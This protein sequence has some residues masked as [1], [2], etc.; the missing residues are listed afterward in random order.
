[1]IVSHLYKIVFI[2]IPKTAGSYTESILHSIDMSC[3]DID[4][5][6]TINYYGHIPFFKIKEMDIYEEIKDY[7]FF[8]VVRD[9]IDLILSHYN[10]ILTCKDEHYLYKDIVNEIITNNSINTILN[11]NY[12]LNLFYITNSLDG[13]N[14]LLSCKS[15]EFDVLNNKI[16]LL[17]FKNISENL[18]K[19]LLSAGVSLEKIEA[20]N[21]KNVVNKSEKYLNNVNFD[22]IEISEENILIIDLN[23]K[24]YYSLKPL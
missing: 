8:C 13:L 14:D 4:Y 2:H 9:P 15:K 5:F 7:T 3:V 24:L 12:F 11:N 18:K 17:D 20:I 22:D 23:K 6:G 1:M 21:F 19:F 10:Y 16:I